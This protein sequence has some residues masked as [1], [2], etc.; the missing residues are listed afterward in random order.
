LINT[1]GKKE[2]I[3]LAEFVDLKHTALILDDMQRDFIEP[4]GVYGELGIDLPMCAELRPR[5]AALLASARLNGALVVHLQRAALPERMGDA[6]SQIRFNVR[7]NEEAHRDEAPLCHTVP[8]T[9]GHEFT[10]DFIPLPNELVVRKYRSTGFWG[11]NLDT[12]LRS[13]G[14]ETVVVGGDATGDCVE[15]TA[16]DAMFNDY[17]VVVPEDCTPCDDEANHEAWVLLMRHRFDMATVEEIQHV[18]ENHTARETEES[19]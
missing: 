15:S 3:E 6:P 9:A 5:L 13:Y 18:W 4:D 7:M 14:I 11:T 17:H 8:G 19:R 10:Q 16:R 12:L 1:E 2:L